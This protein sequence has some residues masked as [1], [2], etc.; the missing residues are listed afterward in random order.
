MRK[1][2]LALYAWFGSGE[3][4]WSGFPS[5][6]EVAEELLFDIPTAEL[7]A[8]AQADDLTEVQLEGAARF[9]GGWSFS[10][11]R[12]E[13]RRTLPP[14]LKRKLLDHTLKSTDEDKLARAR[15][16]FGP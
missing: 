9:F 11:R 13:D 7:V 6:E 16:A 4:P 1:R 14:A 15:K 2:A 5:Y 10:Q 12:L 3:G 8:A